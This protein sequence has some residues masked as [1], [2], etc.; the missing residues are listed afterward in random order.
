MSARLASCAL[1]GLTRRLGG[2]NLGATTTSTCKN[3]SCASLGPLSSYSTVGFHQLLLHKS[4]VSANAAVYNNNVLPVLGSLNVMDGPFW[5]INRSVT[6]KKRL[7]RRLKRKLAAKAE[8]R[9]VAAKEASGEVPQADETAAPQ[10]EA[11]VDFQKS[12]SVKGFQTGQTTKARVQQKGESGQ[13][14]RDLKRK[15]KLDM[16]LAAKRPELAD[17]SFDS[18]GFATFLTWL[19][20]SHAPFFVCNYLD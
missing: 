8:E 9:K 1:T 7:A 19:S 5:Q 17:V 16:R 15:E 13:K 20:P 2:L 6:R 12:I 11:W 18:E 14:L 3:Q 4:T 10:H